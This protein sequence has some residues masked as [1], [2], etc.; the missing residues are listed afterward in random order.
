MDYPAQLLLAPE[1][2]AD[3]Q[4]PPFRIRHHDLIEEQLQQCSGRLRNYTQ[5][6]MSQFIAPITSPQLPLPF[7]TANAAA[8]QCSLL[9]NLPT[10]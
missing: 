9:S 8:L 1:S 4:N 3:A 5:R 2:I 7:C 10:C 6:S